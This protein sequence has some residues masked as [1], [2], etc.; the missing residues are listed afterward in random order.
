[1]F[2]TIFVRKREIHTTKNPAAIRVPCCTEG[3]H[4]GKARRGTENRFPTDSLQQWDSG[5]TYS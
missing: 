4:G 2:L 5:K 3:I 1:M